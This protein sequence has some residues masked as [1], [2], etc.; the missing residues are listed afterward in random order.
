MAALL[1]Y[2]LYLKIKAAVGRRRRQIS[3]WT[4]MEDLWEW[5]E[6]MDAF[7]I[8]GKIFPPARLETGIETGLDRQLF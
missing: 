8:T 1:G 3:E 5:A 2:I 6:N 4:D 7:I